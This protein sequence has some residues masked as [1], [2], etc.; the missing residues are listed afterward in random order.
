MSDV[1]DI[2]K[3]AST[4]LND[5]LQPAAPVADDY[6]KRQDAR[7]ADFDGL[8]SNLRGP[9]QPPPPEPVER[10]SLPQSAFYPVPPAGDLRSS[11]QPL[12][13][14]APPVLPPIPSSNGQ[15]PV[16]EPPLVVK[17]LERPR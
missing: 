16:A 3:E 11:S 14:T 5:L 15:P 1:D 8:I 13:T 7:F 12:G 6:R 17:R 2:L 4:G 9:T 10:P